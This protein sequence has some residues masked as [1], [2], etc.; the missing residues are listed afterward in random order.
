MRGTSAGAVL[1]FTGSPPQTRGVDG[2]IVDLAAF[3]AARIDAS[4]VEVSA[5][6][7]RRE[8]KLTL[9][10]VEDR[11]ELDHAALD[12]LLSWDA[13]QA[14]EFGRQMMHLGGLLRAQQRSRDPEVQKRRELD[15]AKRAKARLVPIV[16]KN[17][18]RLPPL[19]V[20]GWALETFGG[21]TGPDAPAV[22]V[23]MTSAPR[24]ELE[25]KRLV[26][27]YVEHGYAA[28]RVRIV[29]VDHRGRAIPPERMPAS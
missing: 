7:A 11:V 5:S 9:A 10:I 6:A 2:D 26:S 27:D 16:G 8:H 23:R 4:K 15:R 21:H 13:E 18:K 25:A 20:R 12:H 17:G 1:P 24:T 22:W 14:L 19:K 29:A 3:R 28:D